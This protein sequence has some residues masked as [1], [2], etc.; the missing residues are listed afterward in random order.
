MVLNDW[1]DMRVFL[2]LYRARTMAEAAEAL[3]VNASTMTRRLAAL[4]ETFDVQLFDRGRHG[5]TPLDVAHALVPAAE[6]AEAAAMAFANAGAALETGVVGEVR[7]ACPPDAADVLVLPALARLRAEHPQ[8]EVVLL[9]GEATL[10]V[11]RREADVALRVVPARQPDLVA[12]RLMRVRW[13]AASAPARAAQIHDASPQSE[14]EW[15]WIGWAGRNA[16]PPVEAWMQ[17]FAGRSPVLRCD[18]LTTQ[19]AAAARGIG[20]ALV[21]HPSVAHYGLQVLE[22]SARAASSLPEADLFVVTHRALR[23]VPRVR[24]VWDALVAEVEARY[25]ARPGE[26]GA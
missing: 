14:Q 19:I 3:G 5:V 25:P 10:D 2:A 12:R 17:R 6:S 9:P 15:P 21:P 1:S 20:V 4:E 26:A 8:L 11:Q 22:V 7:V 16:A 24:A 18:R 23:R 13:V